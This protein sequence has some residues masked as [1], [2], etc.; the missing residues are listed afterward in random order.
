M[1]IIIIIVVCIIVVII[2]IV[3][4]FG[5][6]HITTVALRHTCRDDSCRIRHV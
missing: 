1:A 3:A 2:I 4:V 6:T 5:Q